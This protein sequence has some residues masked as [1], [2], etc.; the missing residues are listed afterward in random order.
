MVAKG[1]GWFF[2]SVI[3]PLTPCAN[4]KFPIK[5]KDKKK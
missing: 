4:V 3:L 1:M 2:V 5:R